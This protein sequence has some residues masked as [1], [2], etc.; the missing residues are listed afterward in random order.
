MSYPSTCFTGSSPITGIYGYDSLG[1][2][3]AT[4]EAPTPTKQ[5]RKGPSIGHDSRVAHRTLHL[6]VATFFDSSNF[7]SFSLDLVSALTALEAAAG[8][9]KP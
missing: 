9:G 5:Q 2:G 6:V 3:G 8:L 4:I 1:G 7:A